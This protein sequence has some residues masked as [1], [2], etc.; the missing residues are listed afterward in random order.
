MPPSTGSS[1]APSPAPPAIPQNRT[2]NA[3]SRELRQLPLIGR[4]ARSFYFA[5]VGLS[6]L[7]RTQRNARIEGIVGLV[8]CA[9]AL[10]LHITRAEWAVLLFT[11]ALVLILEGLNTAIE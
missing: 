11:I 10:W 2:E 8:A 6:Y 4:I 3:S 1:P 7:F 9:L 5:F